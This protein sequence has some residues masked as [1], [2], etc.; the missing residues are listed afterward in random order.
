MY[1]LNNLKCFITQKSLNIYDNGSIGPLNFLTLSNHIPVD[2]PDP[3]IRLV[4]RNVPEGSKKTKEKRNER[5]GDNSKEEMVELEEEL[6]RTKAKVIGYN[7]P[8]N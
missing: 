3:Y 6:Q 8:K 7:Y 5:K 2:S 1:V 4:I